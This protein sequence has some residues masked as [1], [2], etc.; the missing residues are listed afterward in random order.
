MKYMKSLS[1]AFAVLT[2]ACTVMGQS[3]PFLTGTATA[4]A[5]SGC[6]ETQPTQEYIDAA[7]EHK[8][9]HFQSDDWK[10]SYTVMEAGVMV[11]WRNDPLSAVANFDHVIF[12]DVTNV[13]LDEY[14]TDSFFDVIF[15]HYEGHEAVRDCRS[16]DLRLFEFK[17][18]SSGYDYNARFWVELVDGDHTRETLLVFLVDDMT[19]MTA[20]SKKIMPQLT[21]CE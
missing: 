16:N 4:T 15:E 3:L 17:V 10:R 14:Y 12:C 8:S 2:L 6:P 18:K 11:T 1:L 9:N 13:S 20:Y 19:N 7:L 21:S 5:E